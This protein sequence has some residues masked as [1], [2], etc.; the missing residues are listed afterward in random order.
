MMSEL[1]T[2]R[3]RH[4][5]ISRASAQIPIRGY[6]VYFVAVLPPKWK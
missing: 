4:V 6:V 1:Y 2:I 5:N 3:A